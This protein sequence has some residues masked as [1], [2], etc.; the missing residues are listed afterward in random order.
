MIYVGDF[1]VRKTD[2]ILSKGGGCSSVFTGSKNSGY[3][4]QL[5]GERVTVLERWPT[6]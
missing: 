2:T 1:I 4:G 6:S 3:V 5:C